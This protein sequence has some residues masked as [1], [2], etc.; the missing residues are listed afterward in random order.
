MEEW[1]GGRY[2]FMPF[3]MLHSG[4]KGVEQLVF[5]GIIIPAGSLKG[6]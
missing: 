4:K 3:L 5:A 2:P 6:W 1:K